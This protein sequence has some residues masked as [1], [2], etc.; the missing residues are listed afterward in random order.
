MFIIILI[1]RGG[2]ELENNEI[3]SK[4]ICKDSSGFFL[5]EENKDRSKLSLVL[6][7]SYIPH[8]C[9]DDKV[10]Y[11]VICVDNGVHRYRILK[12]GTEFFL[13]KNGIFSLLS[14][15][16]EEVTFY[17]EV[18]AYYQGLIDKTN[19]KIRSLN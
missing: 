6:H 16:S 17:N 11:D 5:R 13:R 19:Q 14:P 4:V 3:M 15:G 1:G 10:Y 9:E 2:I 7:I 8:Y 18:M 12:V